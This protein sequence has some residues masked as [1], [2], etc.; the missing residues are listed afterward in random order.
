[1]GQFVDLGADATL[2]LSWQ[3]I[4]NEMMWVVVSVNVNIIYGS[5]TEMSSIILIVLSPS[6]SAVGMVDALNIG[7]HSALGLLAGVG[8]L[9]VAGVDLTALANAGVGLGPMD[10]SVKLLLVGKG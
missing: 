4:Y 5:G 2:R 7:L 6:H 9:G 10:A 8:F 3:R 1:M